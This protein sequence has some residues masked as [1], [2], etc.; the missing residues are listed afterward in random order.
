MFDIDINELI[1]DASTNLER[2]VE[3]DTSNGMA[4]AYQLQSIGASL[5]ALAIHII[6]KEA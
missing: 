2:A 5:L 1:R 3:S 4:Q 6:T